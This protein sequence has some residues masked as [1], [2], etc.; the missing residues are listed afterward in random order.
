[1]LN[2]LT[3]QMKKNSIDRP[4][5]SA[6]VFSFCVLFSFSLSAQYIDPYP[7]SS[8]N[9]DKMLEIEN[10]PEVVRQFEALLKEDTANIEYKFKLAKGYNNSNIDRSKALKLL[11]QMESLSQKP[12]GF[13]WELAMA[14]FKNYQFDRAKSV[15]ENLLQNATDEEQK[16]KY[17]KW[18]EQC[19]QSKKMFQEVVPI[20]FE[21][22]GKEVNSE[23]PDYLPVVEP[24]ES[25]LLFTTKRDG[26]V[27]NLYD[28]KGYRPSDIY[29]V[30]HRGN[31]YTRARSIGSP[32]T[33]GNEQTAGR[34]E[35]GQYVVYNV[36]SDEHYNDLFI[37]E[38]G[39]RS[40]MPPKIFD[41]EE[42]NQKT[43]ELGGTLSN[44]GEVF[45]F[46]SDR[47]GG[48]GGY[49]I[50]RVLRLPNGKWGF[51]KNIGPPINTSGDENYPS[52]MDGGK[53]LY[54]S[55]NGHPGMGGR[56]LFKA[57]LDQTS[58]EWKKIQNLGYPINTVEDDLNISFADNPKYAYI[59]AKREDSYGDLDI[60][61]IS[62][63]EKD[64][65]YTLL[66]GQIL[67]SDSSIVNVDV[68]VEVINTEDETLYG[69]YL[70]DKKTRRYKAILPAGKYRIEVLNTIGYQD[71]TNEIKLLGKNDFQEEKR[72]DIVLEPQ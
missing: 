63:L 2:Q 25:N 33:Y 69:S 70:M 5:L 32:N 27:G 24:N 16:E 21:H 22:L 66:H 29:T 54:F 45:Y 40:Y 71:Y 55:S 9:G 31:K 61:R 14:Y 47:E 42:V 46:C 57:E 53:T 30:R 65:D 44:N 34:S 17:S 15:F 72:M 59:A 48:E 23:T 26:V 36:N 11:K 28:F 3:S 1:M 18:V 12:E 39:R 19:D 56:D 67:S 41:S 35:N 7:I 58:G 10:Y 68:L 20:E 49:D 64:D 8:S 6:I 4:A 13:E 50:Y 43:N 52:L 37:S 62:F 60:Y 38:K 51:P